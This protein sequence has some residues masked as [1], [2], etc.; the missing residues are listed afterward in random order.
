VKQNPDRN[1]DIIYTEKLS[2]NKTGALFVTLTLIFTLLL[3]WR[4]NSLSLDWVAILCACFVVIFLFYSINYK[5]LLIRLYPESLKLTFGIF[6]WTVPVDNIG[7]CS[8]DELPVIM[9]YG[10]AGIH[11]MT[12]R[13]RYRASFNFLEYPRVVIAFKKKV[14]P[15][16]DISFSTRNPDEIIRLIQGALVANRAAS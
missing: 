9:K 5:A 16:R 4:V 3:V 6:S 7:E 10:G 1:K 13:K 8:L 11:F 15:V 14:G 2:S 12:I